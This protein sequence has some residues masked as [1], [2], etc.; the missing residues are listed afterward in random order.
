MRVEVT[1]RRG[2]EKNVC[3]CVVIGLL[4]LTVTTSAFAATE[5]VV[6]SVRTTWSS[7]IY[8][9][10][11]VSGPARPYEDIKLYITAVSDY[12]LWVN[13]DEIAHSSADAAFPYD[14]D[15][16]TVDMY[17]L[18]I[19]DNEI[20]IG[21]RVTNDG[22]GDGNGV[23]VDIKAGPEWLGT[24]TVRR[25]SEYLGETLTDFDVAWYYYAGEIT[26]IIPSKYDWYSFNYQQE[27]AIMT[28]MSP[29]QLGVIGD[30]DNYLHDPR[31]EV[32]TGY[33]GD[34]DLGSAEGGGIKLR[35]LEGENIARGKPAEQQELSDGNLLNSHNYSQDPLNTTKFIDLEKIYRLNQSTVFTG[36]KSS[37]Y[38]LYSIRGF[39]IELSLDKFR[40]EEVGVIHEIGVSNKGD[41]GFDYG[42]IDFPDS[43][44][45]Y[46]RYKVIE[47]RINPPKVAEFMVGAVGYAYDGVYESEWIDFGTPNTV[48]N[49]YQ[50][51]WDGTVREGT[52][53]GIQT[54]TAYVNDAGN[55]VESAWSR[56]YTARS[57]AP[58]SPE[59][60]TMIMYKVTMSTQDIEYTP[61]LSDITFSFSDQDQPV[62]T[63]GGYIFP[64]E[65]PMGEDTSFVYTLSYELEPGENIKHLQLAMPGYAVVDDVLSSD[66]NATLT[67]TANDITVT[68]G[69][70]SL[71][72]TFANAIT[73][74]G[75]AG[76]DSLYVSFD[77]QLLKNIHM[78]DGFVFND[79]MNDGAGG[80]KVWE[81]KDLGSK[82]VRTSSIL[83]GLLSETK[84][85]PTVF[86]PNDDGINDFTVI[87]F[88]LTK[89]RTDL[90]IKIY[91][92][93]GSLVTMVYDDVLDPG[94]WFVKDKLNN[95]ALAQ[96][97]PGYWDGRDED[98]DLVPPGVYL[99]QVVADTDDGEKVES[100]TVVVGY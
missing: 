16:R 50:V 24:S 60:A 46:V 77:T 96:R 18:S 89:I 69:P 62:S 20:D 79:T 67:E 8:Y 30:I 3:R 22:V 37:E 13:G 84:V 54:K 83:S 42:Q 1:L 6:D 31:V 71:Y 94:Q 68:S 72:I 52:S 98:G 25:R 9:V 44:G 11:K 78:F 88:T 14:G 23:V 19:N 27:T 57:F 4:L 26:D 81:N 59:P 41:G 35:R 99:Y 91:D 95:I 74:T 5:A 51:A 97:M 93:R 63:V 61:V 29:V 58:E 86:T 56:I 12:D 82:T 34:M 43:W 33:V 80:V 70:D 2:I 39:S 45:R 49:F 15:W 48:K 85:V 36:G 10:G 64:N 21:V 75:G 87:E 66:T 7:T 55:T 92:T 100:G 40:W 32:V 47:S 17:E 90:K 73:D 65:A 53:I 38:D 28:A 76:S